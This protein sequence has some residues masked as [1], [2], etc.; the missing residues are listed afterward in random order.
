M[1]ICIDGRFG[2]GKGEGWG[3]DGRREW[4][5]GDRQEKKSEERTLLAVGIACYVWGSHTH[6]R[7]LMFALSCSAYPAAT[8]SAHLTHKYRPTPL[9]FKLAARPLHPAMQPAMM[10]G[11]F[12]PLAYT[13]T[14]RRTSIQ[15][16]FIRGLLST[17]AKVFCPG[18]GPSDPLLRFCICFTVCPPRAPLA[19]SHNPRTCALDQGTG[20]IGLNRRCTLFCRL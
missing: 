14:V 2:E 11:A 4:G 20:H 15:V 3:K 5:W 10:G 17:A 8:L 1:S 6:K 9:R 16:R 12:L 19:F 18:S 13:C 7:A